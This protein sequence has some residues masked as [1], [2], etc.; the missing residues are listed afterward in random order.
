MPRPGGGMAMRKAE[1][2]ESGLDKAPA[3]QL[4]ARPPRE[5]DRQPPRDKRPDER[6]RNKPP[7]PGDSVP[8]QVRRDPHRKPGVPPR[9]RANYVKYRFHHGDRPQQQ[10]A[11]IRYLFKEPLF[12]SA[13]RITATRP[14]TRESFRQQKV[15]YGNGQ[16]GEMRVA[17][18]GKG[19]YGGSPIDVYSDEYGLVYMETYG[20]NS[21]RVFKVIVNNETDRHMT[22]HEF[23]EE[24]L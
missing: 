11:V 21:R 22:Y 13:L 12:P 5:R 6:R 10:A 23:M 4:R 20:A 17:L 19:Y 8:P 14:L 18:V 1:S 7:R 16:Y 2:K 3:Q 9:Y 15:P 24:V